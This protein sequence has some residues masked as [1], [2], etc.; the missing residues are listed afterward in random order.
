MK[1]TAQS[2]T[3]DFPSILL[4]FAVVV[5]I[6]TLSLIPD[7]QYGLGA[8][9]AEFNNLGHI[10]AYGVLAFATHMVL[11]RAMRLNGWVMLSV[12]LFV[13]AFGLILEIAQG[14]VGRMTSVN[15]I[16]LNAVGTILGIGAFVLLNR[17][18]LLLTIRRSRK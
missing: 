8:L 12:G 18:G 16:T 10:P 7:R 5:A 14:M 11:S 9:G 13:F 17:A 15:D 4:W 1:T 6:T 3:P 2:L